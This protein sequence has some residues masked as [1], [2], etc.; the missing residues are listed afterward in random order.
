MGKIGTLIAECIKTYFQMNSASKLVGKFQMI[1]GLNMYYEI[2]GE[3]KPLILIHGGG[4][5]IRSTFGHILPELAKTRKLVAVELQSHGHTADRDRPLSFD[6][7]ADDVAGLMKDLAIAK[8]DVMGFSNG[9]TTAL[10]MAIRHPGLVSKL[11]LGSAIY[12]REGM[13]AGFWEG[14]KQASLADMP[15]L[16]KEAYREANPDPQSLL[17]MF[18]RDVARMLDFSDIE[19]K[20]IKAIQAPALIINGDAEVVRSEH[21]QWAAGHSSGRPWRIYWRDL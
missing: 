12:N 8:A 2:H 20:Q 11:V 3:G 16:L 15:A 6:Q 7:D 9:G 21:A 5:T 17:T 13:P 18:N 10:K 1:N 4:S 19:E 14:M